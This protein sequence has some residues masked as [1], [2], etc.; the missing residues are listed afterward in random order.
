VEERLFST[1]GARATE[2]PEI[3]QPQQNKKNFF[4]TLN[5]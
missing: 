4:K 2:H 3:K 5:L 1:N